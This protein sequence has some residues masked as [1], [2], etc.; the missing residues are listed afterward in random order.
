MTLIVA[1]PPY[2]EHL[3]EWKEKVISETGGTVEILPFYGS[4]RGKNYPHDYSDAERALVLGEQNDFYDRKDESI[5]RYTCGVPCWAGARYIY[6]HWNGDVHRCPSPFVPKIGNLLDRNFRLSDRPTPCESDYCGCSDL[7]KY[8]VEE[9]VPDGV[10]DK[11]R[12][13]GV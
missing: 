6:V 5:V 2:L 4:Y 13:A 7:W 1:Y 11:P 3:G 9:A 12:K 8:M 10:T